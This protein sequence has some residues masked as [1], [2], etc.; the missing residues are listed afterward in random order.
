MKNSTIG[1]K[2]RMGVGALL[3]LVMVLALANA[4]VLRH[5]QMSQHALV[6]QALP[7]LTA[8]A[9]ISENAAFIHATLLQH[10]LGGSNSDQAQ[11]ESA[12]LAAMAEGDRQWAELPP[13]LSSPKQKLLFAR[14]TGSRLAYNEARNEVLKLSRAGKRSEAEL[15]GNALLKPAYDAYQAG[16]DEL[17]AESITA[18]GSADAR[19]TQALDQSVLAM[20]AVSLSAILAGIG[21]AAAVV[22]GLKRL[23]A[24]IETS[25]SDDSDPALDPAPPS[26]DETDE[27]PL[28]SEETVVPAEEKAECADLEPLPEKFAVPEQIR[29]RSAMLARRTVR[30]V[31][32]R[33]RNRRSNQ[34]PGK[35]DLPGF[36]F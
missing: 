25:R 36:C 30:P 6:Q 12:L 7:L 17:F 20:T 11:T 9:R 4:A 10:L 24:R 27:Q 28:A 31:P 19:I 18:A 26:A 3:A 5:F 33:N 21:L 14:A 29:R 34:S 2:V 13:L 35:D 22:A 16:C 8:S 32:R 23:V 15:C 1:K